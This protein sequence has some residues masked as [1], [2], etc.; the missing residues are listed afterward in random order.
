MAKKELFF[1]L[2]TEASKKLDDIACVIK[3]DGFRQGY[4]SL[5]FD[6]HRMEKCALSGSLLFLSNKFMVVFEK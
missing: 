2:T 1:V 3:C 4:A 6:F 5:L